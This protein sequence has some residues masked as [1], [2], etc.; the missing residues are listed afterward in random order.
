MNI[1]IGDIAEHIYEVPHDDYGYWNNLEEDK[2]E[3]PFLSIKTMENIS[4]NNSYEE[5]ICMICLF[6]K[7][8]IVFVPCGYLCCC[9]NCIQKLLQEKCPACNDNYDKYISVITP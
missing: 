1:F 5:G 9:K 6:E 8:Q 2:E 7:S 3:M 4:T